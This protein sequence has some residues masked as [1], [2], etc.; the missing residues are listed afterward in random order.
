MHILLWEWDF[1]VVLVQGVVDSSEH[2]AG[3][4]ASHQGF[5][6]D[7]ELEVN[8][9]VAQLRDACKDVFRWVCA[10][11]VQVVDGV[12]YQS[13]HLCNIRAVGHAEGDNLQYVAVVARQVLI[14]L[15]EQLCILESD[16]LTC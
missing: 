6:P 5:R 2:L 7:V 15:R 1:D 4:N 9:A 16:Y 12:F 8:A 3:D 14:V 11:Q 13:L 10:I